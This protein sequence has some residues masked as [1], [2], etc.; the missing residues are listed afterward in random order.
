MFFRLLFFACGK[1]QR[2]VIFHLGLWRKARVCCLFTKR[3]S[4]NRVFRNQI[5]VLVP[6]RAWRFESSFR[7]NKLQGINGNGN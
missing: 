7:H 1:A 3:C 6:A 5:Q 2:I 4:I